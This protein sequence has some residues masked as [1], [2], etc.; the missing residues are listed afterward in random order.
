MELSTLKELL[1]FILLSFFIT[2][3]NYGAQIQGTL[4]W[5]TV[6][7]FGL[8]QP[9]IDSQ[10]FW[11]ILSESKCSFITSSAS[12][13][14]MISMLSLVEFSTCSSSLSMKEIKLFAIANWLFHMS[15]FL[16]LFMS[17]KYGLILLSILQ[18]MVFYFTVTSTLTLSLLLLYSM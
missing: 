8:N 9:L 17:F 10:L 15:D 7:N 2:L 6:V 3:I 11:Y 4:T 16:R 5:Y 1:V 18:L 13:L 12:S 14:I